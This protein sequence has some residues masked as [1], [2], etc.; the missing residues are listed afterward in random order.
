MN[1]K[2]SIRLE[3]KRIT[4]RKLKVSDAE[5]VFKNWASDDEVSKYM[6]WT[7][8]KSVEDTINWLREEEK[9]YKKHN[10]Y[11]WGIE[12]KETK[13]LIG[14]ISALYRKEERRYEIGYGIG[15][16][17]WRQGYTTESLRR[18]MDFLINEV[19]IKKF[20][21]AHAK[22]NPV[23]G[24]VM[25]KVGFKYVKDDYYESFDRTK[26]YESKVYYLDIK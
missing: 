5:Q 7:T 11:T 6:R 2:G 19:G 1:H 16:K 15:K 3:T 8:H 18:V 23:S 20:R 21:C 9:N 24:I 12:L 17:Y 10:Y 4:L 22:L 25:Q 26:K 13:E 14:S